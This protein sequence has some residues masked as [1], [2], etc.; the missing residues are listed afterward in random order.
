MKTTTRYINVTDRRGRVETIDEYT[1]DDQ[2]AAYLIGEY[3]LVYR[4][5]TDY[6]VTLSDECTDDWRTR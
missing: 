5:S 3:R 4:G 6:T 1:G 2:G